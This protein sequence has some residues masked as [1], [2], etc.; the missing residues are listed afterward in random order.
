MLFLVRIIDDNF[1]RTPNEFII[2]NRCFQEIYLKQYKNFGCT[3]NA[4]I[5]VNGFWQIYLRPRNNFEC[6]LNACMIVNFLFLTDLFEACI[7]VNGFNR[8]TQDR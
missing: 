6:M 1:G 4:C 3:P 7:I 8:F 2:V 5:T